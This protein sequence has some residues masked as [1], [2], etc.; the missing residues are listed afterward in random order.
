MRIEDYGFIGDTHTGALVGR[1][2]SI[3]WLCLPRFDGEACFAAL[4]GDGE[5]GHWQIS[6]SGGDSRTT[7]RYLGDSL[8]LETTFES[9]DGAV[10]LVDFMP[11]REH[12]QERLDVVRIVRGI[13]GRVSMAFDL[14]VRFDYGSV[15]P[16][17][18][19]RDFGISAVAG[20]HA[21]D[22]HSSVPLVG[23]DFHTV[24]TFEVTAGEELSF[25]MT[26][27][28]SHLPSHRPLDP[29]RALEQTRQWWQH[30]SQRCNF[31][32]PYRDVAMRSLV[33][34]KGLTYRP[35]GGLIAA[36]TTSLPELIG[37]VRNWDY[38][39]C[40]LRD[41]TFALYA[42]LVSGY[43]EEALAWRSWL[44]R[45]VAGM[46]RDVQIMYGIRGERR[47]TELDLQWLP[48]YEGSAPVR[49]GNGAH[50]QFQ[51][52]VYGEV[53]DVLETARGAGVEGDHAGDA[54]ALQRVLL[55]SL[56]SVWQQPDNGIWESR[57]DPRHFTHSKIM[58][59][60]AFDRAV[61][62]VE[63][64]KMEGPADHWRALG[65][66][67]HREVCEKG[68]D[69][70]LNSFVQS[71]GSTKLDASLLMAAMV[72]F[73]PANDPRIVGTV[74]AIQAGLTQD[75]FVLRNAADGTVEGLPPGEGAFLAC[76]FWL[77]DNLAM[78][79]RHDQA[80]ALFERLL[81][82]RND[83]GLLAEEYDP[84]AK[85]QLGNFPQAFSHVGLINAAH[86][87][88]TGDGPAMKRSRRSGTPDGGV[89]QPSP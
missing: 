74:D 17:V 36:A 44:L 79:G 54:W 49:I 81:A 56:E 10:E 62:A 23:R 27:R 21:L 3:D 69:T 77:V 16:W 37:G 42:L 82:V 50:K 83:L 6:P 88:M 2:G 1:N 43:T 11:L 45:A 40:W 38:R 30:W 25:V 20:P 89:R 7:R 15:I 47:L 66:Q 57:G 19:R 48:G 80:H 84:V 61:K 14:V 76:S 28:Q 65:D 55:E 9:A 26:W 63:R 52:D 31:P 73:L 39:Y 60:V 4:L 46:P 75:G 29:R 59:G 58:A 68:F 12:T 67:V 24:A 51:L 53:M 85:R 87:L 86:N 35:T 8:I 34:L 64:S 41:A 72:G 13:R 22:V 5:H 32:E 78:I 18:Q 33:T 70:S 71:Y